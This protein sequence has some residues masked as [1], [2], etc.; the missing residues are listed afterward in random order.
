MSDRG[1]NWLSMW[2]DQRPNN[3]LALAGMPPASDVASP[4]F[5]NTP[6]PIDGQPMYLGQAPTFRGVADNVL[7]Q[8][9]G[10]APRGLTSD[11]V[12]RQFALRQRPLAVPLAVGG[13]AAATGGE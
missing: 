8:Y 13:A 7:A 10:T 2:G 5:R 3:A 1:A 6:S 9:M 11:E 12:F 4:I